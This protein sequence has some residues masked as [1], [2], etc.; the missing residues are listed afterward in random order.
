MMR[1]FKRNQLDPID[2][3]PVFRT[4]PVLEA[5]SHTLMKITSMCLVTHHSAEIAG[6]STITDD[7]ARMRRERQRFESAK[8]LSLGLAKGITDEVYRDI[9]L[10]E[11]VELCMKANDVTTARLLVRVIQTQTIREKILDRHPVAFY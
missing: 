4:D 6:S 1:W 2:E 10:H 11:V 3:T 8:R 5:E 7:D 9:A